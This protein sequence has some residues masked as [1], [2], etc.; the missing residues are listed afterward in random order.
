MIISDRDTK[1]L[2]SFWRSIFEKLGVQLL[3]STAYHPQTDKQ[4]ERTNQS[5]EIGLQYFL[6]EN[7][8]EEWVSFLPYLQALFNNSP[9][10]STGLASNEVAYG[11]KVNDPLS[12]LSGDLPPED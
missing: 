6:T 1:F 5:V 10:A 12:L 9:N 8:D 2:S 11:N 3:T 7:P 4:S